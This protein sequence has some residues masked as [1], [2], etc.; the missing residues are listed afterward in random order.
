MS[1]AKQYV[2]AVQLHDLT[3]PWVQTY[4][5]DPVR[6]VQLNKYVAEKLQEAERNADPQIFRAVLEKADPTV[7]KQI[8]NEIFRQ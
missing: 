7:L 4:D 6:T 5:Q 3:Y 1:A 2:L 8:Q